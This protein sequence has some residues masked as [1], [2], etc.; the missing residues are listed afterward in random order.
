MLVGILVCLVYGVALVGLQRL[1]GVPYTDLASSES[2][3]RRGALV[4]V[5]VG[6]GVAAHGICKVRRPPRTLGERGL[7][8]FTMAMRVLLMDH[9]TWW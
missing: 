4:P 7:S 6:A 5:A 1:S 8:T 3:M 2:N 9:T